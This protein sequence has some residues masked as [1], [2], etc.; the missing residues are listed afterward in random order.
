MFLRW[1][2]YIC[3]LGI[4]HPAILQHMKDCGVSKNL[5]EDV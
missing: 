2:V 1:K 3:H 4:L 5:V